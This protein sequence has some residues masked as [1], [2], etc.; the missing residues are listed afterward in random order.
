MNTAGTIRSLWTQ[1]KAIRLS[2]IHL[3]DDTIVRLGFAEAS[4]DEVRPF[5]R[6]KASAAKVLSSDQCTLSTLSVGDGA[7]GPRGQ[8][9]H[10]GETSEGSEGYVA[11][12]LGNDDDLLWLAFFDF[13]NPFEWDT[14][15]IIDEQRFAVKTNH[16][17]DWTFSFD[18]PTNI[19][20]EKGDFGW[21]LDSY[22]GR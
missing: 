10:A 8:R 15:R 16:R 14:L 22:W 19:T 2:G 4:D 13:S 7:V 18:D 6:G 5:V 20:V 17:A 1:R 3:P 21:P 12:C 9:I 11:V